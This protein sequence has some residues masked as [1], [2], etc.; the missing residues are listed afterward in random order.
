[1]LPSGSWLRLASQR[2]PLARIEVLDRLPLSSPLVLTDARI[3]SLMSHKTWLRWIRTCPPVVAVD[4]YWESPTTGIYRVTHRR[5]TFDRAFQR[6]RV[7][8]RFPSWVERG[9]ATWIVSGSKE[10]IN[11]LVKELQKVLPEVSV[12]SLRQGLLDYAPPVLTE[13][14]RGLVAQALLAGYFDVPKRIS[15]TDLATHLQMAKGNLS[16]DLGIAER[17]L[18]LWNGPVRDTSYQTGN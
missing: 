3:H 13:K 9:H 17:K 14:Q 18:L 2:D 15:L 8:R 11:L 16:R 6:F 7:P 12:E 10:Q 1:M 4:Y 5:Q